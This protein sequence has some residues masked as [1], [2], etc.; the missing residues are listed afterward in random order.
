MSDEERQR[1]TD[2]I[3]EY[4]AKPVA[5]V[6][7]ANVKVE[8]ES[9]ARMNQAFAKYLKTVTECTQALQD[10]RARPDELGR[11]SDS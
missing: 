11:Y 4:R 8:C 7:V 2:L 9:Q 10:G 3:L 1:L 6:P 5:H